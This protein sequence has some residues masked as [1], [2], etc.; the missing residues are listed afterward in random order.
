[1]TYVKTLVEAQ[2][3]DILAGLNL[4]HKNYIFKFIDL[5]LNAKISEFKG[6]LM[7]I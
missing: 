2:G 1:M 6:T 5:F 4:A 7:Q 3:S